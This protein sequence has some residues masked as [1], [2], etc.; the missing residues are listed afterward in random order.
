[1]YTIIFRPKA[2]QQLK[3]LDPLIQQRILNVLDR[4]KIN[5]FSHDITRLVGSS[6]YRAKAGKYRI[7]LDIKQDKLI[8][9]VIEIGL[10]HKIYDKY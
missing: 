5:P 6:Y 1:M 8:I 2:E 10:R 9:I 7:I 4:L 3:K